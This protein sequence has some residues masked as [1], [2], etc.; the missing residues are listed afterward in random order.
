MVCARRST[1]G[2]KLLSKG[3]GSR[4]AVASRGE[5]AARASREEEL[6]HPASAT[7]LSPREKEAHPSAH[8]RF[9][10]SEGRDASLPCIGRFVSTCKYGS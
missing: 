2:V 9:T 10:G 4:V 8:E 7:S 5:V 6:F 1:L 3:S